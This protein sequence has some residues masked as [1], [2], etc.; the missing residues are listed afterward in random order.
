MPPYSSK[1][2][3]N[4][5]ITPRQIY[6]LKISQDRAFVKEIRD[7]SGFIPKEIFLY[8]LSLTHS[9][10]VRKNNSSA[11]PARECNERLEFLGDSILDSVV[12]EYLFKMYPTKDEGFLTEM[13]SK[14]VNRKSLNEICKKIRLSNLI[15]H[16]QNGTVNRSMYG[17][18]LEAFIGAIYLDLGY[19]KVRSFILRRILDPHIHM[20]RV[21]KQIISY[22]N[23]LIE[24]VQKKKLGILE[25]E[26]LDEIG[27]GPH[28]TFRVQSMVG[29]RVLGFGEGKNKKTAEQ[30][31]SEDALIKLS[32]LPSQQEEEE[33]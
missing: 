12:A 22:K 5:V 23:K 16:N 10:L 18:A 32:A 15:Q 33:D 7:I 31:A 6:N 13:R 3:R 25:F 29:K 11:E 17:D 27:E 28:K 26:V 21:E 9:S 20:N 19:W 8:H 24:Y 4:K 30:R 2:W 1:E 14:I